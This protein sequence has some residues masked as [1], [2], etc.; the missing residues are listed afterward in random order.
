MKLCDFFKKLDIILKLNNFEP[1]DAIEYCE[2]TLETPGKHAR[3]FCLGRGSFFEALLSDCEL[4]TTEIKHKFPV[5]E[6]IVLRNHKEFNLSTLSED[7]EI[8]DTEAK[9]SLQILQTK[10]KDWAKIRAEAIS[11]FNNTFLELTTNEVTCSA[12]MLGLVFSKDVVTPRILL[13]F[14]IDRENRQL[15]EAL[16]KCLKSQDISVCAIENYKTGLRF[17]QILNPTK[18]WEDANSG[19]IQ[20]LKNT[21]MTNLAPALSFN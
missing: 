4:F 10:C 2:G 19:L 13:Q 17:I 3:L 20:G 6:F 8:N 12:I 7:L 11:K 15:S 16:M 21:I 5:E 1:I 14:Q 9:R 18:N